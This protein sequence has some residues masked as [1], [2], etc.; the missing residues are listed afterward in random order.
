MDGHLA[1]MERLTDA[2]VRVR[3]PAWIVTLGLVVPLVLLE[4]LL[5]LTSSVPLGRPL[6]VVLGAGA[7]LGCV[8]TLAVTGISELT[9]PSAYRS[10]RDALLPAWGRWARRTADLAARV[11]VVML[12]GGILL[13]VP[14]TIAG[15]VLRWDLDA[16]GAPVGAFLRAVATAALL[17]L[18]PAGGV[19]LV[20]ELDQRVRRHRA[21]RLA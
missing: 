13:I 14:E 3:R 18:L 11:L 15:E 20:A 19:Y 9:S 2:L 12:V 5:G 4:V 7:L 1:R 10:G 17:L 21:R 6:E 8:L 16:V